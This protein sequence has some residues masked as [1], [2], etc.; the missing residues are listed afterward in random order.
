MEILERNCFRWLLTGQVLKFQDKSA[1]YRTSSILAYRVR[2]ISCC[3][4][5]DDIVVQS[6]IIVI[7]RNVK[8]C[9]AFSQVLSSKYGK[10]WMKLLHSIFYRTSGTLAYQVG[11]ISCCCLHDVVV[12]Q[13]NVVVNS[14]NVKLRVAFSWVLSSKYGK[15]RIKL[16]QSTFNRT[17]GTL[18]YRVCCISCC[19][20]HHVVVVQSSVVVISS[21]VKLCVAFSRVFS[22]KQ[23]YISILSYGKSKQNCFS[24]LFTG[25]SVLWLTESAASVVIVQS[26]VVVFSSNVKLCVAFSWVFSSKRISIQLKSE[27]R[28][29][30][31]ESRR[32]LL[33]STF[34]RTSG[35]PK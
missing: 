32:K 14:S 13:S 2:C 23:I 15:S 6:S 5:H 31:V 33:Q 25:Q 24:R 22:S 3:C 17:S 34:Y 9:V 16:L 20:L 26:S 7:S 12:L 10:S 29:S 18:A 4:L 35:K 11:C 30:Q 21:N 28:N 8:L 1:F 27:G 19:C